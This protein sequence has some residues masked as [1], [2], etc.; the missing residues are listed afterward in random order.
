M[1]DSQSFLLDLRDAP[2]WKNL[3]MDSSILSDV[4]G[5][6]AKNFLPNEM[7]LMKPSNRL[8]SRVQSAA[9]GS[10][11]I[12]YMDYG[13]DVLIEPSATDNHYL[14]DLPLTGKT[15]VNTG[16]S[17]TEI[18]KGFIGISPVTRP[19]KYVQEADCSVFTL[20]VPRKTLEQYL[21]EQTG[22]PI[23]EPIE[24]QLKTGTDEGGGQSFL[25]VMMHLCTM[26]QSEKS[27]LSR[28]IVANAAER[29]A[30][31]TLLNTIPHNYSSWLTDTASIPDSAP[32]Y[33]VQAE[34]FILSHLDQSIELDDLLKV[35]NVSARSLFYGFKKYKGISPIAYARRERLRQAH[36]EL[37]N[38][39]PGSTTVTDVATKWRFFNLGSFSTLYA[40]KYGE[41]PSA[42]LSHIRVQY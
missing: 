16:C 19:V 7:H 41:K 27:S 40:K 33:V 9:L 2:F 24:F 6:V 3:L 13:T 21:I 31:V 35:T 42:T 8:K 20:M 15:H 14:I 29:Y 38:N 17:D 23:H 28:S 11:S 1:M 5:V 39:D 37:L 18:E 4:Q 36:Q 32:Y 25:Q 22:S 30:L 12:S 34:N 10:T 26:L